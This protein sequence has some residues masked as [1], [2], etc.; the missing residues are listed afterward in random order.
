MIQNADVG[1]HIFFRR[2]DMS[3]HGN[4]LN[5]KWFCAK[6][7]KGY[8]GDMS[9]RIKES[10]LNGLARSVDHEI[11]VESEFANHEVS[12]MFSNSQKY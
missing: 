11:P 6:V 7:C 3:F 4:I 8:V 12:Y 2:H 1:D 5:T 10:N 9:G